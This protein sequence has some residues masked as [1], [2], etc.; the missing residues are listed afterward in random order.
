MQFAFRGSRKYVGVIAAG[1]LAALLALALGSGASAKTRAH[2]KHS[3]RTTSGATISSV[4]WGSAGGK[5][6]R[7][8]TLSNSNGMTVKITNYGG[9]IQSIWVPSKSSGVADVA[10]GFRSLGDYVNDFQHQPWPASGGSGDTYFGSAV[11]RYANRIA[12][13]MFTLNGKTYNLVG[14]NGP[15]N[16][17]TLHG[18]PN[19]WNTRVWS[20]STKTSANSVALVLS[21]TDPAG[22]NG[23]PGAVTVQVTYKLT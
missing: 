2:A 11:G 17:N 5:A 8:W 15:N 1:A 10:L 20:A 12:N 4:P 7:L 18:G 22:Y 13:H 3:A 6:V 21:M 16:I 23:F 19:A 14:N 9:V